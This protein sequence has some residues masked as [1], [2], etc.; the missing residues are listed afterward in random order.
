MGEQLI[1]SVSHY[2]GKPG[3]AALE[4]TTGELRVGDTIRIVGHTTDFTQTITEMQVE[5]EA[6]TEAKAGDQ[7]GIK[8]GD[9]ARV[10]DRVFVVD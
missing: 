10:H 5:H 8:V 7:V 4:V 9:R 3:V 1:G 2:F 6:V